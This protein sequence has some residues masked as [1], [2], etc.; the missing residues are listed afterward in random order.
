MRFTRLDTGN[1][2]VTSA[3]LERV[4][5]DPRMPALLPRCLGETATAGE[6]ALFG[7]L[8][9][10]RVRSLLLEHADDPKTIVVIPPRAS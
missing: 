5:S 9:Q 8:W 4:A 1:A 6:V 10:A 3:R 7:S 2:V